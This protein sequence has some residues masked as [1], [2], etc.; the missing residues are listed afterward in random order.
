MTASKTYAIVY[1]DWTAY[2]GGSF[3]YTPFPAELVDNM[4]TALVDFNATSGNCGIE[5][6]W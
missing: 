5:Y 2:I 1:Y 3:A 6:N 4:I